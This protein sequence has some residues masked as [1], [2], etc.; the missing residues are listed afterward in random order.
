[1]AKSR[2]RGTGG[3]QGSYDPAGVDPEMKRTL[4]GGDDPVP[5]RPKPAPKMNPIQQGVDFLKKALNSTGS[6][7]SP[8]TVRD[9]GAPKPLTDAERDR[10][11]KRYLGK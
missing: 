5:P 2:M 8:S 10:L 6:H 4:Q 1:M 7:T 9:A 3:H 11:S